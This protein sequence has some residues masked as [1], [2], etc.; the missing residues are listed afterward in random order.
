MLRNK[1]ELLPQECNGNYLFSNV[2]ACVT[3]SFLDTFGQEATTIMLL[4]QSMIVD[5]Y[6]NPDWLQV[7]RYGD[8]KF[9]CMSGFEKGNKP[10]DY[11]DTE[12]FYITFM[13]PCDY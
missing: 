9:W 7:F 6:E 11:D 12:F 3:P 13:L 10:S 5:T 8:T 1:L 2:K 4:A